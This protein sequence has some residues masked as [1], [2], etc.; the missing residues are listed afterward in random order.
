MNPPTLRLCI[1]LALLGMALQLVGILVA[2]YY[3][4]QAN[5]LIYSP[6]NHFVSELTAPTLSPKASVMSA[7][8]AIGSLLSLPSFWALARLIG[9]WLASLAL[10]AAGISS[11]AVITLAL[12][13]MENL[14]PHLIA[15]SVFFWSWLLTVLLFGVAFARRFS[16]RAAP[17]FGLSSLL[18][19]LASAAFL[20]I[21]YGSGIL[22]NPQM[23]QF[24]SAQLLKFLRDTSRPAIWMIALLEWSVVASVFIWILAN[25]RFLSKSAQTA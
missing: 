18:A 14:G 6:L 10:A 7:G 2:V 23:L 16:F 9:G 1:R 4:N 12:T 22:R 25:L 17:V 11:L 19:L 15:A 21:L 5:Q 13:P 3:F 8:L 24:D 20:A